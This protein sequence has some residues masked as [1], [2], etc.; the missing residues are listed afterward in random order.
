MM[1]QFFNYLKAKD[2]E[3]ENR[4]DDYLGFEINF[5]VFQAEPKMPTSSV[6]S[7]KPLGDRKKKTESARKGT[8][9]EI[10]KKFMKKIKE[11]GL[12]EEDAEILYETKI[13]W[14]A[15]YS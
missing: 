2:D 7:R 1:E 10:P 8:K 12:K 4:N 3:K 9:K 13:D 6:S 14:T 5:G 15:V 11:L